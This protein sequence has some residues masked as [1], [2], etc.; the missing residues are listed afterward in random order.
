MVILQ[1]NKL[2]RN[3][4]VWGVFAVVI[5][6]AFCFDDLFT[7]REREERIGGE[8]GKLA[9]ESVKAVDFESVADDVRGLGRNRDWR[10][11]TSEVNRIAWETLAALVVA[12]RNGIAATDAEVRETIRR[13]RSFAVNGQFS[14]S[15]YQRLLRENSVTPERF[16]EFL[17]RRLTM[18]RIEDQMLEAAT[19]VSP[20][21]IDLA[22]ADMT[23]TFNVRVARFRQTQAEA[24][25]VTIDDAGLKK[26]YDEN[27]TS[28]AL[29]E[30]IK[31]RLVKF[32]ATKT[33]VQEKMTVTEDDMRD[34]YDATIDKYTSTDTNGVE[35]VK[36]FD[37]V[38]GEIEK[39][40]RLVA[41]VQ[42]YETNLNHRA[43][44]VASEPGVSRLDS[45]AKEEGLE[46]ETSDWFTLEGGYVEGFMKYASSICPGAKGFAEAVAELDSSSEDLRYGVVSSDNAV[47]LVEKID[48]SPAHTPSFEE[49]KDA[50]RPRALRDAQADAFKSSVEAIAAKG[51]EAVLATENVSSNI[52]FAVCDLKQGD[53]ADQNAIARA[54][55]KLSKGEVS[56]FAKT[57][58]RSGLL[59]VCE[60]RQPGDA[61]KATLLSAQ[62]RDEV[63]RLQSGQIPELWRKWNLDRLGYETTDL[64][65]VEEVEDAEETDE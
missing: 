63:S 21:E 37:E 15:L 47:W 44:A 50:I 11:K 6:A 43:Y 38:K 61:A 60:D 48:V 16:E 29:P 28:I 22:V 2:I 55:R 27:S 57:G 31:V 65:S 40:L 25:A 1:F 58:A 41:T 46:V 18:G 52:T 14:F 56:E 20:A 34:H 54:V 12:D 23:D 49:A 3:K 33:D 64:S 45:I 39:D 53:F 13:D 62:V 10:R 19:W 32:D 17:K 4:W 36:T 5:S 59:V 26:W 42:F 9:G 24:D 30:R 7:T 8:F 51:A 35:V